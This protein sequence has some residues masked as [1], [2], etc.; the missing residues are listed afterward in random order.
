M[1]ACFTDM[2]S[3]IIYLICND[4]ISTI[5]KTKVGMKNLANSD[6]LKYY[7]ALA[8][9]VCKS[10]DVN[11]VKDYSRTYFADWLKHRNS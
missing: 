1:Y 11:M 10:G 3:L 6:T 5:E 8:S 4:I 7:S 9:Y 2:H